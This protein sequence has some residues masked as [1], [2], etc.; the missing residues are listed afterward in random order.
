M[1]KS[2]ENSVDRRNF[3]KLAAGSAA[4]LVASAPRAS[5]QETGVRPSEAHTFEGAKKV[6]VPTTER[7]AETA[8]GNPYTQGM[9]AFISGLRYER[10]PEEVI[11]RIKLLILDSVGCALY[12]VDLEW[13]RILMR[14]LQQLDSSKSCGVWGTSLRLSAPHA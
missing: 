9:A 2:E 10:I 12:G 4:A 1:L 6:N 3:L 8:A 11:D 14:T 5:A 7:A 13:S